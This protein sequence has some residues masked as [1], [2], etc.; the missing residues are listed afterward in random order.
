MYIACFLAPFI[1]QL[2]ILEY[3]QRYGL[4]NVIEQPE[5]ILN[6]I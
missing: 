4:L 5:Y 2:Q 3:L 6:A 1:T